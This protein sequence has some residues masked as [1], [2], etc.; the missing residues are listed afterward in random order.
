[1]SDT[2]TQSR[3]PGIDPSAP[4]PRDFSLTIKRGGVTLSMRVEHPSWTYPNWGL[5]IGVRIEEVGQTRHNTT[6]AR[7]P[8]L[9]IDQATVGDALALFDSVGIVP[10][11]TCGAPAFDPKTCTTNRA[12]ECETC[13]LRRLREDFEREDLPSRIRELKG[14]IKRAEQ[15]KAKG[16]THHLL[17]MIHPTAGDDYAVEFYWK[18]EPKPVEIE[19]L[20]K[21]RGSEILNDP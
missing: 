2:N 4:L 14:D 10:C 19:A 7:K 6:S 13:F 9:P 1:M 20:L 11:S 16:F 5:Q 17:S 21:K 18:A 3:H 15:H 12:G 8:D